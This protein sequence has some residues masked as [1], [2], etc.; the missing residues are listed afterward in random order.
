MGISDTQVLSQPELR[1]W[2][3]LA[4]GQANLFARLDMDLQASHNV[5]LDDYTV[6]V[7][8]SEAPNMQLRMSELALVSAMPKSRLTYRIDHLLS[9]GLVTREPCID[10][11]RGSFARITPEGEALLDVAAP[12]HLE[13]VRNYLLAHANDDEMEAIGRVFHRVLNSFSTPR[14]RNFSGSVNF[15]KPAAEYSARG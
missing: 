10:D 6:L 14:Q 3:N 1:A 5:T 15:S 12:T 4:R 7:L 9:R 8:L 13:G 2:H 11:K